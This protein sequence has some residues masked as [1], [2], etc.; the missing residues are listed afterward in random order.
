MIFYS[1]TFF[2]SDKGNTGQV[3]AVKT[4]RVHEQYRDALKFEGTIYNDIALVKVKIPF[5]LNHAVGYA[6][7]P[8]RNSPLPKNGECFITGRL[9]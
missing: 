4:V 1:A 2:R 9:A 5:Y 3:R 8:Q 6:C 7:L